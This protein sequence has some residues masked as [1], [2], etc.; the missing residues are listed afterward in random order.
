[1]FKKF[2]VLLFTMKILTLYLAKDSIDE[3]CYNS[4]MKQQSVDQDIIV[5]STVKISI[6]N[7]FVVEIPQ[8]FPLPVRVAISINRAIEVIKKKKYDYLFKVDNDVILPP[9]YLINL[10]SKK[11]II[12]PGPAMVLDFHFFE[13]YYGCKW[14][15][16]FC[17]DTYMKAYAFAKGFIEDLWEKN[18]KIRLIGEWKPSKF[19][20]YIYG[21]EYHKFG[22]PIFYMVLIVL[23][24]IK[25]FLLKRPDRI[26]VVCSIRYFSGFLSEIGRKKY[27]W[28]KDFNRRFSALL[29][30][31][32]LISFLGKLIHKS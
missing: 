32:F 7:N 29:G 30:K 15:L 16:S 26:P 9:D 3:I 24:S 25:N 23:A 22:F 1:M 28:S 4:V 13:K 18:I 6:P 11:P 10:I 20:S 14:P 8:N 2:K 5:I 17:D 27:A 12:G 31:K 19:R 21:K